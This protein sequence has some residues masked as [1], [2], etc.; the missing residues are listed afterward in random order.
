MRLSPAPNSAAVSWPF[1]DLMRGFNSAQLL[2]DFSW[3]QRTENNKNDHQKL[4][5]A[6][7]H[8]QNYNDGKILTNDKNPALDFKHQRSEFHQPS[9]I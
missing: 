1:F 6:D 4:T 8:P 5:P 9:R 3:P 7:K 2:W